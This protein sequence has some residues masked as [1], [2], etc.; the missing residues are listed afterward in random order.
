MTLPNIPN[1][2]VSDQVMLLLR[3]PEVGQIGY[4]VE[5]VYRAVKEWQVAQHRVPW[6]IL[7]HD[8]PSTFRGRQGRCTLRIALTYEGPLQIELI[9]V[10]DG[11]TI[12]IGA[13]S[14]PEGQIHHLGFLVRNLDHRLE[15]CQRNG[16][17]VIQKGTIKSA[18]MTVDY[19]YLDTSAVGGPDLILE[20]IQWRLGPFPIPVNRLVFNVSCALGSQTVFRGKIV[21]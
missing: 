21:K 17:Q 4:V 10:L 1:D 2:I 19:A 14:K 9:Q 3:L 12:H 6:L 18:G 11:E 15:H 7:D 5:D 16:A 13:A 8:H 20:L